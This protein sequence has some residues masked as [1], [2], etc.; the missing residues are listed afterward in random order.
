MDSTLNQHFT[1]KKL[2]LYTIPTVVMMIATS[3]YTVV[4][5]LF[6][7]NVVGDMA[8][9]G[10]NFVFPVVFALGV[11]GFM[12]GTGGSA[13]VSKRFGQGK[14]EEGNQIFSMLVYITAIVGAILGLA[15]FFLIDP[16]VSALGA[17][18]AMFPYAST[19]GRVLACFL[20]FV[21]E[22][23]AFQSFMVVAGKP[24]LGF[25]FSVI[26]GLTN[27]LGDFLFVYVFRLGVMG[28]AIASGIS[29]VVGT[30]LPVLYLLIFRKKTPLHFT[31]FVLNFKALWKSTV[32]GLS[33]MVSNLS[34]SVV[35]ILF[36]SQLM[37]LFGENGVSAY[38]IIGYLGFIFT[39]IY[40]GYA[41]GVSPVISFHYGA[42][43][44][45]EIQS[46]L[47]KSLVIYLVLSLVLPTISILSARVLSMAFSG[48]NEELLALATHA[49][50]L[51][52]ISYFI[53]G[54]SIFSSAFFTALNNGIVSGVLSFLRTFLFQIICIFTIP[55]IF[56]KDGLWLSILFSE[57]LSLLASIFFFIK[58][59]KR[60]GYFP[61]RKKEI[62]KE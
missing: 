35:G 25:L 30:A 53:S 1:Y 2:I 36:N 56:G 61:E 39:G 4:D 38:G 24:G 33:E 40:Y 10:V 14:F 52:S 45:K 47:K 49:V 16:I 62:Q 46:L 37:L 43:N 58:E 26:A 6:I 59:N 55:L 54:F 7:S 27:I 29:Q 41:S 19:Y 57:A 50:R 48:G 13:L 51:Y 9:S 17:S 28:A 42:K 20:P 32:N 21:M 34:A 8:F 11:F 15:T 12:F 60:Y 31:R 3:I 22:M 18:E 5:G 23:Y 44:Q